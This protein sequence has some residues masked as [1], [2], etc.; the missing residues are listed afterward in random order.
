MPYK[1]KDNK[2][3]Y[4]KKW[5]LDNRERLQDIRELQRRSDR[6]VKRDWIL[7]YL[8]MMFCEDCGLSFSGRTWLA[9]FHHVD[10]SGKKYRGVSKI[11]ELGFMRLV[12]ELNRGIYLCP[13]CH[14][15]RHVKENMSRSLGRQTVSKTVEAGPTPALLA[16]APL[17]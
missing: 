2:K 10:R 3:K 12:Q 16:N 13:N 11:S 15:T 17:A 7:S 6:K 1:D 14:R 8:E 9:D 5:W 4:Q